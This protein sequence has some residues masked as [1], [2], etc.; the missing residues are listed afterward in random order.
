M[1]L[2]MYEKNACIQYYLS[3][4]L[5]DNNLI[6][7]QEKRIG[8]ARSLLLRVMTGIVFDFDCDKR[9]RERERERTGE[10][11]RKKERERE[12]REG[13]K[14]KREYQDITQNANSLDCETEYTAN[15][16]KQSVL[17]IRHQT[18]EMSMTVKLLP[19]S[20]HQFV[21]RQTHR[22]LQSL[23]TIRICL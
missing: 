1:K 13:D 19:A 10:G 14:K 17:A 23:L 18:A 15:S 16:H 22:P 12:R 9:E 5:Q 8:R 21:I 11:G 4:I 2:C 3:A 6:I 7:I 20:P